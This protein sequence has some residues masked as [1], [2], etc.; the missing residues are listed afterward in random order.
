MR[1]LKPIPIYPNNVTYILRENYINIRSYIDQLSRN[2]P[3]RYCFLF[4]AFIDSMSYLGTS[5]FFPEV[6]LLIY[7]SYHCLYFAFCWTWIISL[8]CTHSL[9]TFTSQAFVIYWYSISRIRTVGS[10]RMVYTRVSCPTAVGCTYSPILFVSI[11][12]CYIVQHPSIGRV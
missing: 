4:Y 8:N 5:C 6:L 9:A 1:S 2:K 3:C 12:N 10:D 11:H 7:C